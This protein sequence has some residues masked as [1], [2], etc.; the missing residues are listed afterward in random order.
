MDQTWLDDLGLRLTHRCP[1]PLDVPFTA[2]QAHTLGVSRETLRHLVRAELVRP[3]LRGVYVAS[4]APDTM[5]MRARGLALVLPES[6]VV[7]DRTAAWLHGVAILPRTARTVVPPVQAFFT[8]DTRML[9]PGVS[10]GRR[11]LLASDVTVVHGVRVTTALRTALDLGRLL[12]R[13]DALAAIDGFL[14]IGVPHEL[15]WAEVGRFRGFRGV[16]QLRALVPL[17]DRRA[18]SPA[19]SALR[20]HW[21]DAGL[22]RPQ[23]QVWVYDD[24]GVGR[25]RLDIADEDR[26]FV[27][28]Y[29]GED[30]HTED[31]DRS[32]DEERRDWCSRKRGWSFEIFTKA[33]IYARGPDPLPRLAG[34]WAA[35][36]RRLLW[37]P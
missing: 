2:P 37:T 28:E 21:Y 7:T 32:Y 15:M 20:L 22:P 36:R 27:A 9:R 19:E 12:W 3:Q 33:D 23:L 8:T 4:Q 13:F 16:I 5:L 17:G 24:H 14:R 11:A 30:H 31:E 26:L 6:A 29:D 10:S 18:E 1:L 34:S 35:A 25:Y